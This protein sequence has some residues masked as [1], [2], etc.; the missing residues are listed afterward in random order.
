MKEIHDDTRNAF[1]DGSPFRR[2]EDRLGLDRSKARWWITP[3]APPR[4]ARS[5][6]VF[7]A[8]RQGSRV[9]GTSD[10]AAFQGVMVGCRR[11]PWRMGHARRSGHAC[12]QQRLRLWI[13]ALI[14][15]TEAGFQDPDRQAGGGPG[16]GAEMGK[17][18]GGRGYYDPH[19]RPDPLPP[20]RQ[21][22]R[23]PGLRSRGGRFLKRQARGGK[24]RFPQDGYGPPHPRRA[25]AARY[26]ARSRSHRP[27]RA[28]KDHG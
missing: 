8:A 1:I 23:L 21:R 26:K 24:A 9:A 17:H 15:V 13:T 3:F 6:R 5:P 2:G 12:Q 7:P 22:Q 14:T 25:C 20:G 19:I 18:G 4:A 11:Q 10:D 16:G 28:A 27:R